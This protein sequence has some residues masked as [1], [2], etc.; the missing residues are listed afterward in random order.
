MVNKNFNWSINSPMN[1]VAMNSSLFFSLLYSIPKVDPTG[2][3]L[4]I[5]K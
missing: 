5:C 4:T 2:K 3:P 1:I